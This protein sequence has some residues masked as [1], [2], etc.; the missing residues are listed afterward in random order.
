[1]KV[2]ALLSDPEIV[3]KILRRLKLPDR[4]PPIAPARL[5]ADLFYP[6]Q[7]ERPGVESFDEEFAQ[8]IW[9]GSEPDP[10]IRT[11]SAG[12]DPPESRGFG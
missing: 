6:A 2:L 1:M 8:P 10:A 4:P 3:Q 9:P 12:R 11:G 7:E 5:P